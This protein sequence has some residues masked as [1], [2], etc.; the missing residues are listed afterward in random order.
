M[1][2]ED[3]TVEYKSPYIDMLHSLIRKDEDE[4]WYELEIKNIHRTRIWGIKAQLKFYDSND[5]FLGFEYDEHEQYLLPNRSLALGMSATIPENTEYA[6]L[7]IDA[8]KEEQETFFQTYFIE[9]LVFSIA[10]FAFY[11]YFIK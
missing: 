11:K 3:I 6:K 7:T 5:N 2:I 8:V 4:E 10:V 1:K 9:L